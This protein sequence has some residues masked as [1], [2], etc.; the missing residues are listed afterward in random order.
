M[1]AVVAEREFR[2]PC[3]E[4]DLHASVASSDLCMR[5]YGVRAERHYL[6][7]DGMR[8]ACIFDAPDAEAMRS[9]VRTAGFAPPKAIWS[10][11]IHPGDGDN[12]K[13]LPR[14]SDP[15]HALAIVERSFPEPVSFAD[16][17]AIEKRSGGCLSLHRVRFLRSY[18]SIDGRRMLCLYE[19][20]DVESVRFANR[21]AGLPFDL[22]WGAAVLN[23]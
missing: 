8:V 21:Q 7:T 1:T 16:V 22:A 10:A 23:G 4:D 2:S 12:G 13:G 5:L 9:V 3:G 11:V 19:A 17:D 18:F 6:A 15:A 14:L 20:P